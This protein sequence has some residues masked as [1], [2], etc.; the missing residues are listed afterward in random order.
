MN[1][2]TLVE[3]TIL[4]IVNYASYDYEILNINSQSDRYKE[5]HKDEMSI[6]NDMTHNKYDFTLFYKKDSI[7]GMMSNFLKYVLNNPGCTITVEQIPNNPYV[8]CLSFPAVSECGI[9][10]YLPLLTTRKL[11]H[12]VKTCGCKIVPKKQNRSVVDDNK[13]LLWDLCLKGKSDI[14]YGVYAPIADIAK[15]VGMTINGWY[16]FIPAEQYDESAANDA[17]VRFNSAEWFNAVQHN[18]TLIGAGGLGSNIAVSLSRLLGNKILEIYDPDYIEYKNLAGQNFG[19][20]DVGYAKA[21]VVAVQCANF[22]PSI[23]AIQY[24]NRFEGFNNLCTPKATITGLD[25]MASRSYVYYKWKEKIDKSADDDHVILI[26]ARL[27]AETWQVFC[28]TSDNKKAQEEYETKWLFTDEEADEGICTYKQ[29][30]F[31]A[32]MCASFV[33]NLYVNFCTNCIKKQDEP[34]RRFLP[35]MTE[36]DATQMILRFQDI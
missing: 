2:S 32:Q 30:A 22:N 34:T 15:K 21:S 17:S 14:K 26:D 1:R 19:V 33:T 28:V 20:T 24:L 29:T 10:A 7:K 9:N 6:F 11:L 4:T 8:F 16:T 35:F 31:A 5:Q 23:N 36:Y 13:A 18:V 25:N 3:G 12:T 27:S